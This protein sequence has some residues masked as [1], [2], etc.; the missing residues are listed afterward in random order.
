MHANNS[1]A[2]GTTI[3]YVNFL[4]FVF[5]ATDKITVNAMPPHMRGHSACAYSSASPCEHCPDRA[6]QRS[7]NLWSDSAV[8][9]RSVISSRSYKV[10]VCLRCIIEPPV[11]STD[12]W[13][14]SI[15][16]A[17]S[18]GSQARFYET[19]SQKGGTTFRDST[20]IEVKPLLKVYRLRHV[21]FYL[22]LVTFMGVLSIGVLG[23]IL[24]EVV[25]ALVMLIGRISRP[26]DAVLGSVDGVDG[27]QDIEG[28]ANSQ[29]VPGLIAY[30][31]DAPHFFA[32]ADHFLREV[33][34]LLD[35][36]DPPVEWLLLDAEAIIDID[37]TAAEAFS[38]LQH[39]LE[40]KGIVLAIARANHPLRH[41]LKRAGLIER[42]GAQHFYPT[43][44]TGVQA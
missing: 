33:Q 4:T 14:W 17:N 36:A 31:I 23:G 13:C 29:T 40:R 32:N 27:Y 21:E 19:F 2:T 1:R 6:T 34:E 35:A 18:C 24:V 5:A 44:R 41:M 16:A 22:A 38:I 15:R 28:Y 42:F 10:V 25:L 9:T 39:Q 3:R 11:R 8:L 26:H 20:L 12:H 30:R 43:V 37:V 7:R